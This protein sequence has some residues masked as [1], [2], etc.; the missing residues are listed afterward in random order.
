MQNIHTNKVP[1]FSTTNKVLN[2][3]TKNAFTLVE[4]I[5]VITIL[6]ILWTI[7]FISLQWYSAQA[8]DSK[9]VSDIQNIKKSLE[10]FSLNTWKYPKPDN[11]WIAKYEW[12]DLWYQWTVWSNVTT[13]LSRNLTKKP[14]DP[15]TETEYTY[16]TIE[17][18]TQYE[19]LATYESDLVSHN[20]NLLN[21]TNASNQVYSKIS[22]TYNW[23]F[24]KA[25]N[26][27]VPTPSIINSELT[28]SELILDNT[29][30]KSQII[31]WWENN[32]ANTWIEASIWKLEWMELQAFSWTLDT[33]TWEDDWW[34]KA[35]LLSKL[36]LA[37]TWTRLANDWIYKKILETTETEDTISL[38]DNLV[39]NSN[40]YSFSS[41]SWTQIVTYSC[42]WTLPTQNVSTSNNT[43]LTVD[44]PWQNTAS[45][46]DCYYECTPW[47]TWTNC[48]VEQL[49]WWRAI[50][51]NEACQ[52]DD[53]HVPEWC[54]EWTEWCQVWAWCNTTQWN[55]IEYSDES[56]CYNYDKDWN[57]SIDNLWDWNT[58]L[59]WW[60][61]TCWVWNYWDSNDNALDYYNSLA[62]DWN[63]NNDVELD[64]IWWKL[65]TW[66]DSWETTWVNLDN[67]WDW[68]I[69]EAEDDEVCPWWYHIPSDAEWST[70][71]QSLWC[72]LSEASRTTRWCDWQWWKYHIT[73]NSSTSI[74]EVLKLPLAGYRGSD[75]STFLTRGSN[76]YLWSS[77]SSST[78]A[79]DRSLNW[80]NSSVHRNAN[81]QVYGFSVRCL[82]D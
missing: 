49:L 67:N 76:L 66:Y 75:G 18:Q 34:F 11:P 74:A 53:I 71:E 1:V 39:F 31:T 9:R 32:L 33:D 30:I 23:I 42:T 13:N 8:R 56:Y 14:T 58:S 60:N 50:S 2:T 40:T 59:L 65:Y 17:S 68:I 51:W 52:I 29:N 41:D 37:Y 12:Q 55:W 22:G 28:W 46:D 69:S 48:D 4:L 57:W 10:L 73:T 35:D 44:T 21:K 5:V 7:A 27:I 64:N 6:A 77:T 79:Y 24:V 43:W 45:W 26:Y 19:L 80:Y 70:L 25:G 3:G 62:W 36:Q 16:S 20:N 78:S 63:Q 72:D 54:I 38:V 61:W 15:L 47:Y 81:S 82:K